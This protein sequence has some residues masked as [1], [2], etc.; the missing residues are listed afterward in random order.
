MRLALAAL[1]LTA[2]PALAVETPLSAQQFEAYATGKTLTYSLSGEVF[3]TE[4]Y[5]PNRRVRWAYTGDICQEGHW[6]EDADLI[7]FVYDGEPEP[8]CWQFWQ[9]E[10]G[11]HAR[12][13][14]DPEGT[15]LSEVEQTEKPLYCAGP[16]VGV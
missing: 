15:E 5:L 7:C 3:G 10:T 2:L 14:N 9:T 1:L 6:Y 8:Q 4:Q 12:F 13:N 11:L 16:D